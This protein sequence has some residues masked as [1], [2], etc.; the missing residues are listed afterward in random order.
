LGVGVGDAAQQE[1]GAYGN[2]FGDHFRVPFCGPWGA[3]SAACFSD[4]FGQA[5][6]RPRRGLLFACAKRSKSTLKGRSV[7]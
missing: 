1:F 3:A 6:G 4:R 7:P 5:A 2:Q